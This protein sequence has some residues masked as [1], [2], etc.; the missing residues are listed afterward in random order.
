[1]KKQLALLLL[2]VCLLFASFFSISCNKKKTSDKRTAEKEKEAKAEPV[3][4]PFCGEE[5]AQGTEAERPVAVMVE[6]LR[7][8]RPQYGLGSACFVV[9]ALAEGGITRFMAVYSNKDVDRIG[10]VRSAR[11]HYVAI[12]CGLDA[13]YAHCGGST[14]AKQ[15]IKS[16]GVADLDQMRWGKAYWRTKGGAPHNLW[17]STDKIRS[18][19]DTAGYDEEVETTGFKFKSDLKADERP[20]TQ[21]ITI[22][23]STAAYQVQYQYKKDSNSYRRINGGAVQTDRAS[24]QELDPKNIVVVYSPT[25][26]IPGGGE[27]LDV[28]VTG[29]NKCLVFMDGKVIEGTWE[30]TSEKAPFHLYNSEMEEIALNRGQT[31]IELVKTNTS[32]TYEQGEVKDKEDDEES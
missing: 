23:F 19:A 6:N 28:K 31:W 29:K 25:T 5:L 20:E 32:V 3:Y 12:A 30:K 1:M 21:S 26:G 15:A 27:V 11:T 9:E 16:W 22:N 8:I 4:C 17:T 13:I 10:P 2:A 24:G 18:V 14:Y 7:S